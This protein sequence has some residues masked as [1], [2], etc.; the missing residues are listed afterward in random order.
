MSFGW[1]C[2]EAESTV[3]ADVI[4]QLPLH[5]VESI[6]NGNINIFVRMVSTRFPINDNLPARHNHIHPHIIDIAF[7]AMMMRRGY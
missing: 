5:S 6:G 3:F 2:L 4:F 7:V 1:M